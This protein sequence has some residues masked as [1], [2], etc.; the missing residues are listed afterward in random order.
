MK[1]TRMLPLGILLVL[2][3][4]CFMNPVIA[5]EAPS[6]L[7]PICDPAQNTRGFMNR[8]GQGV[9]EPVFGFDF[10]FAGK[11]FLAE[12]TFPYSGPSYY[13]VIDREGHLA[14]GPVVMNTTRGFNGWF[15][16]YDE[17]ILL[18]DYIF[19]LADDSLQR[20]NYLLDAPL[21]D[22]P[23]ADDPFSEGLR[24][25]EVPRDDGSPRY[26][27]ADEN[28]QMVIE[29]RFE[30]AAPFQNEL[31]FVKENGDYCY[32]DREGDVVWSSRRMNP[33]EKSAVQ[34]AS[35]PCTGTWNELLQGKFGGF[36]LGES[37]VQLQE[38][39]VPLRVYRNGIG[40]E[41]SSL[42]LEHAYYEPTCEDRIEYITATDFDI[43]GIRPGMNAGQI[44]TLIGPAAATLWDSTLFYEGISLPDHGGT[45]CIEFHLDES[46]LWAKLELYLGW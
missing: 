23:S 15:D 43:G 41:D 27:Y 22:T 7:Y 36:T 31:A 45:V 4:C 35:V 6:P 1:R 42:R 21:E 44:E 16:V 25:V 11:Y 12:A 28:G 3:V 13:C 32:I 20:L 26:G 37:M 8:Q 17:H 46:G 29:A 39:D 10:S 9:I 34:Q 19:L 38:S 24:I 14:A 18:G 2:M 40:P 30:E 5:K 33:Q